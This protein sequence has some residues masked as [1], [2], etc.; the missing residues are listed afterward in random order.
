MMDNLHFLTKFHVL[1]STKTTFASGDI[2]PR[3]SAATSTCRCS[4][5]SAWWWGSRPGCWRTPPALT[6]SIKVLSG[7]RYNFLSFRGAQKRLSQAEMRYFVRSAKRCCRCI[8]G[9]MY[10]AKSPRIWRSVQCTVYSVHCTGGGRG[11]VLNSGT[12]DSN[13][14]NSPKYNDDISLHISQYLTSGRR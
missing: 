13:R 9:L 3:Y 11:C 10:S 2:P 7:H 4:S 1:T 6:R 14:Q 5:S 12:L 8:L